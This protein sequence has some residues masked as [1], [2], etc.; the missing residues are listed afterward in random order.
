VKT[1]GAK[2]PDWVH[3]TYKSRARP[4]ICYIKQI[5]R[6]F[7][8]AF[9]CLLVKKSVKSAQ[10]L[11]QY[12]ATSCALAL[13]PVSARAARNYPQTYQQMAV[14]K[15]AQLGDWRLT[16]IQVL[17]AGSPLLAQCI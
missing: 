9:L 2:L 12:C 15:V 7:C 3:L 10:L 17:N 1:Q 6:Y 11:A 13:A 8:M 4:F 14:Q 16:A 5:D